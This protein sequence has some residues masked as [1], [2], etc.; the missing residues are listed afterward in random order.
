VK[1]SGGKHFFVKPPLSGEG[2]L[3]K[4]CY[5]ESKSL[6]SLTLSVRWNLNFHSTSVSSPM[7]K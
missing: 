5:R 7:Q 1:A 4:K 6:I 3:P 2:A